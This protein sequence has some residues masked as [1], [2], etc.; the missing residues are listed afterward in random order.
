M[1]S[2]L[3]INEWRRSAARA[4]AD[5]ALK[6]VCSWYE[7]ID[8]DAL[9]TLR[10][11]APTMIDPVLQEKRQQRAYQIARYASVG[12]FI[13]APPDAEDEESDEEESDEEAIDEETAMEDAA[14][15]PVNPAVQD[16]SSSQQNPEST[17]P[18]PEAGAA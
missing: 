11:D 7:G 16:P 18:A 2:G 6:F 3:Q 8:L 15:V 4:G 13:P 9:A 5:M 10:A 17:S 1:D 14:S 12:K